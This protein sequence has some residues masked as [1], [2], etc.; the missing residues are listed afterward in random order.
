MG[1][2]GF[3]DSIYLGDRA[4]KRIVLDTWKSELLIQ[5]T[6]I[7]RARGGAWNFDT[8]EDIDDGYLVFEGVKA[9]RFDPSGL[10]MND[11]IGD[12]EIISDS[13]SRLHVRIHGEHGGDAGNSVGVFIEV[14]AEDVA[15]AAS[16]D[17]SGRIRT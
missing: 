9:V 12:I 6:C 4:C 15:I 14:E 1:K 11:L 13:P 10:M 16:E 3:L 17:V 8:S 7:S 2:R 5:V